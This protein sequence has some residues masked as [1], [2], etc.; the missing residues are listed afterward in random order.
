[1]RAGR[2]HACAR[3]AIRFD[4]G[5]SSQGASACPRCHG[6]REIFDGADP[7]ARLVAREALLSRARRSFSA[8]LFGHVIA[9]PIVASWTPEARDGS[10]V[11][12]CGIA[13]GDERLRAPLSRA[14]CL[15]WRLYGEGPTGA[16]DEAGATSFELEGDPEGGCEIDARA[17]GVA[18][19]PMPPPSLVDA[20]DPPL[21]ELLARLFA[22]P[23]EGPLH[24]AEVVL[25]AGDP[26]RAHGWAEQA[27][28]ADGYRGARAVRR[29]V[30]RPGAPLTIRFDRTAEPTSR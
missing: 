5:A 17:I 30:D 9:R 28:R 22:Y 12:A 1:M 7:A 6:T 2:T 29:F 19:D 10:G 11:T 3:C 18:L 25:R 23:T 13:R 8:R 20:P 15:A 24:L 27:A 14:P 21:I 4:A 16:L 26:V